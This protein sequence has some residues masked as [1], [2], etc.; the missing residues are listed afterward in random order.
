[1]T[2]GYQQ[3]APILDGLSLSI[4]APGLYRVAGSNGSGKSTL[5]ELISG[6]LQPWKGTVRLCG[7]DADTP[8]ARH[9]RSVCRTAPALYPS[10]TVKDHLALAARS[11]R[12]DQEDSVGRLAAYGLQ[13][14]IEQPVS[15]LSTGNIR[16]LWILMCTLGDTPIIAIDEPFNGMDSQ[17]TDA[18]IRELSDWARS[19]IV[20]LVAHAVPDGLVVNHSFVF[21]RSQ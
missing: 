21:Q 12:V 13:D 17:G 4:D 15:A 19:K 10:M 8:E 16:K 9:V 3:D 2:V 7:I 11:R 6:F 20:I 18:L 1:M 14:W 5:L